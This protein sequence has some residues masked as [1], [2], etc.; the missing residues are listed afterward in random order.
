M[1]EGLLFEE[2]L[3][4]RVESRKPKSKSRKRTPP[5][6]YVSDRVG[7]RTFKKRKTQKN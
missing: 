7:G 3:R 1:I 5:K 6:I 4:K 2:N